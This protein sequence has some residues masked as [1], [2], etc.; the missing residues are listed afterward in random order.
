MRA[1]VAR[2]FPVSARCGVPADAQAF[3]LNVTAV[4][5][6]TLTYVTVWPG[7]QAQPL[8]STLNA[9]TGQ[10]T[11]AAA[12]T[13]AGNGSVSVFASDDSDIVVDVNGYFSRAAGGL[14][15]FATQPCRA[16]DTRG[17]S[18]IPPPPLPAASTRLVDLAFSNCAVPTEAKAVALNTTAVPQGYLGYVTVWPNGQTQPLASTLNSWNGQVAANFGIL[19]LGAQGAVSAFISNESHLVVD[20]SGYFAP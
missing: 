3:A 19:P 11:A 13:P 7:G 5:K 1:G 6:G 8:A 12:I 15:F 16:L 2:E 18:L 17:F 20:V 4:P 9:P 14:R 10:V